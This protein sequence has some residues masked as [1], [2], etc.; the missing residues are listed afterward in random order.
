MRKAQQVSKLK[1]GHIIH[2]IHR[3]EVESPI[4]DWLQEAYEASEIL[5]RKVLP[6]KRQARKE[7][8]Q[9]NSRKEIPM[10]FL[11]LLGLMFCSVALPRKWRDRVAGL[12]GSIFEKA[13][14]KRS[15]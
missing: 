11:P 6:R 8:S 13:K 3:D 12:V 9:Y 4:T 15:W 7:S 2:I 5:K 14:P 10:K 1:V